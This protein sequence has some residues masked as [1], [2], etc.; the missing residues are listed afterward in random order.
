MRAGRPSD[1]PA[2]RGLDW[3]P[4]PAEIPWATAAPRTTDDMLLCA[5]ILALATAAPCEPPLAPAAAQA[6]AVQ[7]QDVQV[8]WFAGTWDDLLA[9]AKRE[10]RLVFVEFWTSWCVWCR[11]LERTTLRDPAV[12]GELKDVLCYAIDAESERGKPLAKAFHVRTYPTLVFLNPDGEVRDVLTDYLAPEAFLAQVRRIE[13][14]EGTLHH[15]RDLVKTDP[16]D[17]EARFQLAQKLEKLGDAAGAEEQIRAILERDPEGRSA[18]ARRVRLNTLLS[19]VKQDL[20]LEPVYAYLGEGPPAELAYPAWQAVWTYERLHF[21]RAR[22]PEEA[23]P[24]LAKW[25]EA[26]RSLWSTVPDDLRAS[27]GNN[28]AWYLYEYRKHLVPDDL[29]FALEVARRCAEIAPRDPYVV[30][31]LACCLFAL[32]HREEALTTIRRCIELDPKNPQW[33]SRLEGFLSAG[34]KDG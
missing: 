29:R 15:L 10:E 2:R 24:H 17:L 23:A 31:T 27:V 8:P 9:S 18:P 7:A 1:D 25:L 26:C 6:A 32:G 4:E 3:R 21:D 12:V 30:D 5:P 33:Q 16:G 13:R 20:R 19:G 34:S 22:S 14:N 28:V 11:K